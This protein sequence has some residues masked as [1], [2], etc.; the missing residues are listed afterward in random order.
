MNMR[1]LVSAVVLALAIFGVG[2]L[3]SN[4]YSNGKNTVSG[5][6]S[7]SESRMDSFLSGEGGYEYNPLIDFDSVGPSLVY[8][9][10]IT[11]DTIIDINHPDAV[12]NFNRFA[13][14][15][16]G[17]ESIKKDY[18]E[19]LSPPGICGDS[20]TPP[21]GKISISLDFATV[22]VANAD[23]INRIICSL[24]ENAVN[25]ATESDADPKL[26]SDISKSINFID[27]LAQRWF[28]DWKKNIDPED[29]YYQCFDADVKISV[30][31]CNPRFLTLLCRFYQRMSIYSY[32]YYEMLYTFDL[33][34]GKLLTLNDILLTENIDDITK[35]LQHVI[36]NDSRYNKVVENARSGEYTDSEGIDYGYKKI[37]EIGIKENPDYPTVSLS[38]KGVIFTFGRG[39][40]SFNIYG[41]F[42]FTVPYDRLMSYL[43]P[44]AK[45]L[46]SL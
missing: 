1:Y 43:T 25:D 41:C 35:E 11:R 27:T 18:E 7:S 26:Q 21:T 3:C 16:Q 37:E 36:A 15:I 32:D 23:E 24:A 38:D 42:H 5:L 34:T 44:E 13:G 19:I 39:Y 6:E 14:P 8:C 28:D 29:A 40:I 46:I 22:D 2:S 20:I 33:K 45:K 12:K 4:A 30:Q 31:V 17:F 9:N 10:Y